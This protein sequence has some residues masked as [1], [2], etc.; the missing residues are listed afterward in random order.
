[1]QV[2]TRSIAPVIKSSKIGPA[3]DFDVLAMV[4]LHE[5]MA[6]T[7]PVLP[8]ER[9]RRIA[10]GRLPALTNV[11]GAAMH[12]PS[13]AALRT[14][15]HFDAPLRCSDRTPRFRHQAH[16]TVPRWD[17]PLQGLGMHVV[18]RP[19]ATSAPTAADLSRRTASRAAQGGR[20]GAHRAWTSM[21]WWRTFRRT[22]GA[23]RRVAACWVGQTTCENV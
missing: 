3:V 20:A 11:S 8:M 2:V 12:R 22:H 9:P 21:P 1:M 5:F 10:D 16:V 18:A 14:L 23:P 17:L 4:L 6:G 7:C 19:R 15:L 13:G